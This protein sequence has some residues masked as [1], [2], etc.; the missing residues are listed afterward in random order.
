VLTCAAVISR[1]HNINTPV[2]MDHDS[3]ACGFW[4]SRCEGCSRAKALLHEQTT[5]GF[6]PR[7]AGLIQH[8]SNPVQNPVQLDDLAD[9]EAAELGRCRARL[10]H[11]LAIGLPAKNALLDWNR[12]RLDRLLVDHLLRRGYLNTALQ[13]AE[14]SGIQVSS[15]PEQGC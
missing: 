14:E 5:P 8:V 7:L 1:I 6:C 2:R 13:L 3:H 11:L 4:S 12:R 10:Q 9:V 15:L